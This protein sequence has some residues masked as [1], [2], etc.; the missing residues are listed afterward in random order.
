MTFNT[1]FTALDSDTTVTSFSYVA[2]ANQ[3][4]AGTI[5]A[6]GSITAF[7]AFGT[8]M[9]A[10]KAAAT[11][12]VALAARSLV[13]AKAS[14]VASGRVPLL[15]RDRGSVG[16]KHR[17]RH[18]RAIGSRRRNGEGLDQPGAAHAARRAQRGNRCRKT[19]RG[20][21]FLALSAAAG[22]QASGHQTLSGAARLVARGASAVSARA[23]ATGSVS[24][25]AL[26]AAAKA[27]ATGRAA[28]PRFRRKRV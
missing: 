23:S 26:Q 18:S 3:S 6:S 28:R 14:V 13:T 21:L 11:T 4:A 27:L 2:T 5:T 12:T 7:N 22:A 19:W 24:L 9:V 16:A 8:V 17:Y 15:A 25:I 1:S 20:P 10:F